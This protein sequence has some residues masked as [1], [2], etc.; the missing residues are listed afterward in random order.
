MTRPLSLEYEGAIYHITSRGN[1]REDIFLDDGDR[2]R[3]LEIL[4]DVVARY[5]WICHAYCLMTNHYHHQ[6]HRETR[7]RDAETPR[8]KV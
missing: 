5:G 1:A 7:C 6:C 8:M 4:G 3:F 2:A